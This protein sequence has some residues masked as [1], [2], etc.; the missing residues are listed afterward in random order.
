M[1]QAVV[2]LISKCMLDLDNSVVQYIVI[3]DIEEDLWVLIRTVNMEGQGEAM[4][5]WGI[6][7]ANTSHT[8]EITD[9]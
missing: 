2:I 9:T 5:F 8:G 1:C 3:R 7:I 6:P 4:D